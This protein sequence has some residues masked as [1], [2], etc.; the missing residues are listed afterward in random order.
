MKV[1]KK[2]LLLEGLVLGMLLV[3]IPNS[4][5]QDVQAHSPSAVALSYDDSLNQLTI[6]IT[7]SVSNPSTHYIQEVEIQVN[8]LTNITAQYTSQPDPTQ[9][10]Y[11]YDITLQDGDEVVG[12]ARCNLGGSKSDSFT[13][14][15]TS[16]DSTSD[17]ETTKE[18]N[19]I[20]GYAG[21][22]I[23]MI[24]GIFVWPLLLKNT[25]SIN[26]VRQK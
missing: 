21:F 22:S 9:F 20:A 26:D 23:F 12:I 17:D 11:T 13:F 8:S 4:I 2:T 15:T 3:L 19:T 14:S 18:N 5:L 10:D 7:H 16:S 25:K 1:S 6:E 24:L